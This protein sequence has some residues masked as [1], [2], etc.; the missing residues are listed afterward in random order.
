MLIEVY[1]DTVCPWCY[2]GME[3]LMQALAKR[4]ERAAELRW[5]PF[6]LNPDMPVEGMDR[7]EYMLQKFGDVNRFAGAHRQLCELGAELGIEFDFAA[8]S[9][10]ANTRRS[11]ALLAWAGAGGRQTD[12]NRALLRAYFSQGRDIGDPAVLT[13]IAAECGL[14]G[15]AAAAALE[16]PQLHET[17]EALEAQALQWGISGVPTFIFERRFALSGAQQLPVFL[18]A[19]DATERA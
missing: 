9:R 10:I 15:G 16:D 19:I 4:P 13:A 3:R 7:T 11:H 12:V 18:E 6:E 17:I 5:L 14:D 1:S 2:V 8:I